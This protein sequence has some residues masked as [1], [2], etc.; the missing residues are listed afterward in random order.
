MTFNPQ[1]LDRYITGNYGDDQFKNLHDQCRIEMRDGTCTMDPGHRGRHTTVSFYCDLCGKQRRGQPHH[2]IT[3]MMSDG[4]R[5]PQ[6][7][8][9]FMCMRGIKTPELGPT[10]THDVG[11]ERWRRDQQ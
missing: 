11:G 9:C 6:A 4:Y 1:A 2:V 7:Q 8:A 10:A 5:E 3:E